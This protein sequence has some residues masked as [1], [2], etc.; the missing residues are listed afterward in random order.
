MSPTFFDTLCHVGKVAKECPPGNPLETA[1]RTRNL[2]CQPRRRTGESLR[3]H[4]FH[5]HIGTSTHWR[6][7]ETSKHNLLMTQAQNKGQV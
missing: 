3:K 4:Q 5:H 1:Q 7:T 6:T 2:L